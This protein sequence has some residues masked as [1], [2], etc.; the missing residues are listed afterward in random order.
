MKEKELNQI[1]ADE[2]AKAK[3]PDAFASL[4]TDGENVWISLHQ[5]VR[6]GPSKGM[7]YVYR[8]ISNWFTRSLDSQ[9]DNLWPLILVSGIDIHI[10]CCCRQ[11]V[12]SLMHGSSIMA[13]YHGSSI[14]YAA[15]KCCAHFLLYQIG[16]IG[17]IQ[18]LNEEE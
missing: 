14:S 12:V 13:F 5:H 16:N 7:P 17:L 11:P 1:L 9:I 3:R 8:T 4:H 2:I 10:G 15:A 6:S 18:D